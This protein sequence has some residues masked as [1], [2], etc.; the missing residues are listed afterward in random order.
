MKG[1][2]RGDISLNRR[3]RIL[4]AGLGDVLSGD[5]GVGV[6]AVRCFQKMVPRTCLSVEVG[7][8][9]TRA[10]PLFKSFDHIV[11]FDSFRGGGSPGSIYKLRPADILNESRKNFVRDL[12]LAKILR[13]VA[14][15]PIEVI[16][17]AAE[18][19]ETEWGIELSPL[20][21]SAVPI[22]VGE[23]CGIM[24][25][26]RS[27]DQPVIAELEIGNIPVTR[28]AGRPR[29]HPG[30]ELAST[31]EARKP[32]SPMDHRCRQQAFAG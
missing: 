27:Q 20:V 28:R 12:E 31:E 29:W 22:M 10:L 21:E 5:D 25:D 1:T 32:A 26:W 30:L 16:I 3:P 8:A 24:S 2:W 4:V 7:T 14:N 23:A 6:H 9:L 19:E 15:L 13:T 17:V 11:A 18:P